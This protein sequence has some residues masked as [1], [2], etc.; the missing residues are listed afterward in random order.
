MPPSELRRM[1][2]YI[3]PRAFLGVLAL[4]IFVGI[5]V[6]LFGGPLAF[7]LTSTI[8]CVGLACWFG[9]DLKTRRR[10]AIFPYE[11]GIPRIE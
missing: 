7:G 2:R 1:V 11:D 9:R 4:N 3:L 10:L 8:G 5:P 6:I